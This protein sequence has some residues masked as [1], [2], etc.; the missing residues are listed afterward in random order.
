[1]KI[2]ITYC[3]IEQSSGIFAI[4][5]PTNH[6]IVE[7]DDLNDSALIK[8][9]QSKTDDA[10]NAFKKADAHS[11]KFLGFDYISNQGGVKV[12]VYTSPKVKKIK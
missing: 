1:M 2:K 11:K 10:G 6:E 3:N 4:P 9:I 12:E 7:A 8:Y 5:T